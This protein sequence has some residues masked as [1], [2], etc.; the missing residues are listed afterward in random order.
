M[1]RYFGS[2]IE[3][4]ESSWESQLVNQGF[5]DFDS[6]SPSEEET[7]GVLDLPKKRLGKGPFN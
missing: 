7:P 5:A 1:G 3:S 6:V 2:L 4:W